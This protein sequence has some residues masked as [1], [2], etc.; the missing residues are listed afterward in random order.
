MSSTPRFQVLDGDLPESLDAAGVVETLPFGDWAP[1]DRP[2]VAVNMVATLDGRAA[3]DGRAGPL[4]NEADRQLFQHLRQRGDAVMVG[5]GTVRAEGYRRVMRP[6]HIP[7][8]ERFGVRPNAL[9]VVVSRSLDLPPETP[10]L[11]EPGNEVAIVTDSA[12]ELPPT[13]ARV[14]YLRMPL[15]EALTRL[16]HEHGIRAIV[17]EGGPT[18][19]ASL[20]PH[21]LADELF[22][23]LAPTLAGGADSL[24]ILTGAALDPP[25]RLERAWLLDSG[26]YLFARYVAPAMGAS[27]RST[28]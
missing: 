12:R 5:A 1:A 15:A 14:T 6:E 7:L 19:N 22:L 13:A 25:L 20:F 9:V 18:L 17:C 16:R 8:R 23:T 3:I 2:Y 24:T 4:G 28:P 10:L 21:A 26:G 11:A 27:V